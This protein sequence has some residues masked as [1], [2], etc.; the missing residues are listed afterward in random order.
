M[1]GFDFG[2]IRWG[3]SG[4]RQNGMNDEWEGVFPRFSIWEDFREYVDNANWSCL[5]KGLFL[6]T[7]DRVDGGVGKKGSQSKPIAAFD[8]IC[9]KYI[10]PK[11][12]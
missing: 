5:Q 4:V 1:S 12:F 2:E 11:S 10:L 9:V 8:L 3:A 7:G 6:K